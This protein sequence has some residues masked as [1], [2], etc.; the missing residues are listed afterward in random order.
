MGN[1]RRKRTKIKLRK[2]TRKLGAIQQKILLLLL[3]GFA[4]ACTQSPT[5]Q[6]RI[7][8]D[9]CA[10]WNE[11][12]KRTAE[13][14][15]AALYESRL[16][17]ARGNIDGTTTLV[18]SENGRKRALT[19]HLRAMRVKVPTAWDKKWRMVIFDVPEDEREA[20]DALREHLAC[21]G[22]YKLQ[23]SVAVYPFDCKDEVDFIIELLDIRKYVRFIV[24]ES[25][26]NEPEVKRFFK[27]EHVS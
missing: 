11:I 16:V 14:A 25:I 2:Q 19:Y 3:G 18:L 13:R 8:K 23:Q 26:D 17:E 4:L 27:L 15:I 20:R 6:W 1:G 22:F 21:L 9:V 10:D 5:K 7:I 24:A 12:D